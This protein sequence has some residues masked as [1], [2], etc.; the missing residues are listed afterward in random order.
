MSRHVLIE[1][2]VRNH[3]IFF[4]LHVHVTCSFI[5]LQVQLTEVKSTYVFSDR[6]ARIRRELFF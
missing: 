4:S 5:I 1:G 2:D 3:D 6:S